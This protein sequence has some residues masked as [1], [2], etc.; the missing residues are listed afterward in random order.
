MVNIYIEY[1]INLWSY[2]QGA[3]LALGNSLFSTVK[4]SK[5]ADPNTHILVMVLDCIKHIES[6]LYL[7]LV[8]LVKKY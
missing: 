5:N 3:N 8:G 6:I 1:K 4:L 7:M 2:T